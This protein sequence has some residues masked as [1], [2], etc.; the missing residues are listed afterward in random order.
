MAELP[1]DHDKFTRPCSQACLKGSAVSPSPQREALG[2]IPEDCF[3]E[4]LSIGGLLAR[5]LFD[6]SVDHGL[7]WRILTGGFLQLGNG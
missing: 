5:D 6:L 7:L 3:E 4:W 2:G 1:F